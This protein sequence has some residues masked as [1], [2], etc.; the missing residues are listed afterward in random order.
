MIYPEIG[1][2]FFVLL[3]TKTISVMLIH[4]CGVATKL[5]KDRI[6]RYNISSSQ[7]NVVA[8]IFNDLRLKK[9]ENY[10]LFAL[11][12]FRIDHFAV[13][14]GPPYLFSVIQIPQ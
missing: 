4:I 10:T 5:L 9:K 13:T 11:I 1:Y 2:T 6:F 14:H 12:K 3:T 8:I 7:K